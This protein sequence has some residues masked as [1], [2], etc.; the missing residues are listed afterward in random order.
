MRIKDRY[1]YALVAAIVLAVIAGRVFFFQPFSIPSGSNEPTLLI[2]DYIIGNRAAYG[3]DRYSLAPLPISGRI[4]ASEPERGDMVVFA[5]PNR[6]SPDFGDDFVKRVI[7]LPGD[8]I[9]MVNG[10]VILNGKT[11]P[12]VRISDYVTKDES[13][14]ELRVAQYRETLPGGRSYYTLAENPDAAA[15][16]TGIFFVPPGHYFVLGDNRDNSN[17]S[18]FDV[19]YVPAD[20]LIARASTIIFSMGSSGIRTN[21][22]FTRID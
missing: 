2:G 9:Q 3:Y 4:F 7:G 17:D 15:N 12:R 11:V 16:N 8:H 18:R 14:R 19:G 22:V 13:G 21:R 5:M 20:F 6:N 1:A 10:R